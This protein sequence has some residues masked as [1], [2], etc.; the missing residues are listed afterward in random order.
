[1]RLYGAGSAVRRCVEVPAQQATTLLLDITVWLGGRGFLTLVAELEPV[2]VGGVLVSRATLHNEDEIRN[3]DVRIGDRV[4]VQRAG[5]VIPKWCGPYFSNVPRIRKFR[6]PPMYARPS[7]AAS[8]LEGEVAWRC[9]NVSCPAMIRQSLAHFS[10]QGRLDIEGLGQRWIELLVASGRVKPCRSLRSG[11]TSFL[12]ASGWVNR[13]QVCGFV[14]RAKKK[15]R[16]CAVFFARS[17]SMWVS[18]RRNIG[19]DVRRYGTC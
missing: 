16:R 14:D 9:V 2:N 10:V 18:R 15:K 7:Q 1:M 17:A 13:H 19:G 6:F 8:R 11:L 4:V 12:H 5:D 3:R